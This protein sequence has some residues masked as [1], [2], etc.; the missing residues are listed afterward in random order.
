MTKPSRFRDIPELPIVRW[1]EHPIKL[2]EM[3]VTSR[4]PIVQRPLELGHRIDFSYSGNAD[5]YLFGDDCHAAEISHRWMKRPVCRIAFNA[6]FSGPVVL[7]LRHIVMAERSQKDL[8][9]A[10]TLNGQ[11]LDVGPGAVGKELIE[12]PIPHLSVPPTKPCIL[13]LHCATAVINDLVGNGDMRAI[14][15]GLKELKFINDV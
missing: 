11:S 12:I 5:Q 14:G 9:F 2:P 3:E 8:N 10:V 6:L 1:R 4:P 15:L 7:K 13:I